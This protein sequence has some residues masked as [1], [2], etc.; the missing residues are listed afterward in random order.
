M[1]MSGKVALVT[2]AASGIGRATALKFAEKGAKV[3]IS[4]M[5]EEGGQ[6]TVKMI[7][8]AGGDATFIKTD[9]TD[10][11]SVENL[12]KTV[13][14]TYGRLDYAHNNAGIM[15]KFEALHEKKVEAFDKVIAVNLRSVF[16]CMKYEIPLMLAGGGGAIVN[17]SS[18]AGLVGRP[19]MI[20][21]VASKHAVAGMTKV[22]A[23]EYV[24]QGMRVNAILPGGTMTPL[25]T[26]MDFSPEFA[27]MMANAPDPHPM[28]RMAEPDEIANAVVWL[29]SDEASYVNGSLF[30]VDGGLTAL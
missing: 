24:M 25:V 15:G 6:E 21:Y 20:D 10:A 22:A 28:Q 23:L 14:A 19:G 5:N 16:L 4:D 26:T 27:E 29:C 30:T 9:V 13:E 2:G 11:D 3:V 17:T 18:S 7:Q 12:I 1:S 8:G